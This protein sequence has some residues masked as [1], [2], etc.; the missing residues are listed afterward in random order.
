MCAA[1]DLAFKANPQTRKE[2]SMQGA[3][4]MIKVIAVIAN[5]SYCLTVT[6]TIAY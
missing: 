1:L 3:Q 2:W 5:I 6:N 4:V